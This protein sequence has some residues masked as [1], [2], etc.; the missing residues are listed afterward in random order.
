MSVQD[1]RELS[2]HELA[3]LEPILDQ[4]YLEISDEFTVDLSRVM[5]A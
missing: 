4:M 1:E 5:A 2:M 3:R